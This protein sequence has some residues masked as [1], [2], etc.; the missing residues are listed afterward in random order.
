[1]DVRYTECY[2]AYFNIKYRLVTM[3]IDPAKLY[4]HGR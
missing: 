2:P 3:I 4:I 1:M